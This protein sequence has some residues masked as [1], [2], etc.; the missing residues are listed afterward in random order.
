[1]LRRLTSQSSPHLIDRL[2]LHRL[3]QLFQ[4]P[5]TNDTGLLEGCQQL[6][7]LQVTPPLRS[8]DP[9]Q[10]FVP[11]ARRVRHRLLLHRSQG[12]LL[13]LRASSDDK[14]HELELPAQDLR[15]P[16]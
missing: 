4:S 11:P 13:N 1:M 14:D 9:S 7:S 8:R 12:I 2:Q 5:D 6:Q 15:A 10:Q 3:D 16:G